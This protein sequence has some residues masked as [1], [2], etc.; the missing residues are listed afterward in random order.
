[1]SALNPAQAALKVVYCYD[2]GTGVAE[3]KG[4]VAWKLGNDTTGD[5]RSGDVAGAPYATLDQALQEIRTFEGQELTTQD[6]EIRMVTDDDETSTYGTVDYSGDANHPSTDS[7]NLIFSGWLKAWGDPVFA[8]FSGKWASTSEFSRFGFFKRA[9]GTN[10]HGPKRMTWKGINFTN[11]S[12]SSFD[13]AIVTST[14][15]GS[16][17]R[18]RGCEHNGT[19]SKAGMVSIASGSFTDI[20]YTGCLFFNQE[21]DVR[22]MGNTAAGNYS[23]GIINCYFH[24]TSKSPL[25]F[26][27]DNGIFKKYFNTISSLFNLDG[28]V[29]AY[30][31]FSPFDA[32]T[33]TQRDNN[34][35][36]IQGLA[37]FAKWHSGIT[38]AAFAPAGSQ[39]VFA[40]SGDPDFVSASDPTL[41]DSSPIIDKGAVPTDLN[42]FHSDDPTLNNFDSVDALNFPWGDVLDG[43]IDVA[44]LNGLFSQRGVG[45]IQ[46][47]L[48][49]VQ[50]IAPIASPKN[51]IVFSP[52]YLAAKVTD[53]PD[54]TG[55]CQPRFVQADDITLSTG[56][57]TKD[58]WPLN[59]TSSDNRI[60]FKEDAGGELNATIST[61]IKN[62][63]D[64]LADITTA[65][66]AAGA[67][68]YSVIYNTGTNK[69]EISVSGGAT[70]VQILWNTGTNA[71]NAALK[72]T[73]FRDVDT[74]DQ[75]SHIADDP[76]LQNFYDSN[77]DYEFSTDY[78]G[79]SDPGVDGTWNPLGT[80]DP[81][82]SGVE[83]TD[84]VDAEGVDRWVRTDL[85]TVA[86][87]ADKFHAVQFS[88]G[89]KK[90]ALVAP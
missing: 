48:G 35:Y 74:A 20:S 88:S 47:S 9:S 67:G 55:T 11:T 75:A 83:G 14:T 38:T 37:N 69:I 70:T 65:L 53:D 76:T 89:N 23:I 71:A 31:N 15:T 40:S 41:N 72:W 46:N 39:D 34:R 8:D 85:N 50:P 19:S 26:Q 36:W 5:G 7:F 43:A 52:V 87:M 66:E 63:V 32:K 78:D 58:A 18:M 73:G 82:D 3:T 22:I 64:L 59:I 28:A 29:V 84:G 60:D 49:M 30:E 79:V 77:L 2:P 68:T 57:T 12:T 4:G 44:N 51:I 24:A 61:G 13:V 17:I 42:D 90:S 27:D 86:P 80:G 1:M 10:V 33:R 21:L 25:Q 62:T 56:V 45:P 54:A 16:Y 81:S 6:W